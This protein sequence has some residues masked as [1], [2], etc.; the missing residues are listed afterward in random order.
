[1][2]LMLGDCLERMKEIPT[3]I[4]DMVMC[5]PPYGTTK[6]KWD[7]IIPFDGLWIELWRVC[8][9]TGIVVLTTSQPFTSI[10]VMSAMETFKYS[11]VYEKNNSYWTS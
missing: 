11:L 3:G 1:M 10:A 7:T 8:K 5:D 2:N 9:P 4:V 6:C